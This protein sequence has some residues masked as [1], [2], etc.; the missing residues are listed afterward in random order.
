MRIT[1]SC[2]RL[3]AFK[4]VRPKGMSRVCWMSI[5]PLLR[6]LHYDRVVSEMSAPPA[7]WVAQAPQKEDN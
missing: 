3:K 1:K 5:V 7:P 2:G 6:E 4:G